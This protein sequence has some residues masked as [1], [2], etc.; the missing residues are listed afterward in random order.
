[1]KNICV[2]LIGKHFRMRI[3]FSTASTKLFGKG[4]IEQL[5]Q[6]ISR[7]HEYH[8]ELVTVGENQT[9]RV[10]DVKK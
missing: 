7:H 2:K 3:I 5:S 10:N 6:V 1:M 8:R 4:V 9:N